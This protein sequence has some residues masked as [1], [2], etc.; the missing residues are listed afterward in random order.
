[1]SEK[2][3]IKNLK[4]IKEL[5]DSD[6]PMMVSERITW[7]INDMTKEDY[8]Y[9]QGRSKRQVRSSEIGAFLAFGGLLI[10]LLIIAL[11]AY[12]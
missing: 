4:Q 11:G 10:T 8:T 6:C 9:R 7:L 3:I 1:M 5:A 2:E 12:I